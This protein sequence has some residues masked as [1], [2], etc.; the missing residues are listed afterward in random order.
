VREPEPYTFSAWVRNSGGQDLVA[1][2][3]KEYGGDDVAASMSG[4]WVRVEV[5]DIDVE[6]GQY[7]IGL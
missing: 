7:R 6:T 1:L 2:I 5:N 3:A 4:E